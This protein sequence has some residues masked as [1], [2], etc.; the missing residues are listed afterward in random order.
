[1]A[2]NESGEVAPPIV[3]I[4]DRVLTQPIIGDYSEYDWQSSSIGPV[5][6]DWLVIT[7]ALVLELRKRNVF[8]LAGTYF[9]RK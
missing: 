5:V 4:A 6:H 1:M 8:A 3:Q 7:Y 9:R 2:A